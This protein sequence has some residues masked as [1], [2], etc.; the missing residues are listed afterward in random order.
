MLEADPVG[1][2]PALVVVG[3]LLLAL[4]VTGA[5]VR[6]S[7]PPPLTVTLEKLEGS[8]L[9]HQSFVRLWIRLGAVG[10]TGV[11]DVRLQVA[12]TDSPG[13]HP[14]TLDDDGRVTVRI[15]L[16]P[17]CDA[18]SVGAASSG[19][20]EGTLAVRVRDLEGAERSVQLPVPTDGALERLVRYRCA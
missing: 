17:R 10:A 19:L 16:V 4:V 5:I 1:T 11:D 13:Q 18:P 14:R 6:Q 8:A 15:D 20:P 7:P 2:R 9:S 3:A 12:G